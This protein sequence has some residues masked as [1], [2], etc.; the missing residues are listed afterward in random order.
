MTHTT[1][2]VNVLYDKVYSSE[3]AIAVERAAQTR[4]STEHG[5]SDGYIDYMGRAARRD[6]SQ[7]ETSRRMLG[8]KFLPL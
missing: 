8:F 4:A 6:Y 2:E 5:I 3:E 1:T 7:R